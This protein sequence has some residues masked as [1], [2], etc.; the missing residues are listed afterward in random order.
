MDE[1]F[2]SISSED[3]TIGS[4]DIK[5]IEGFEFPKNDITGEVFPDCCNYHKTLFQNTGEWFKKFPNCCELHKKVALKY[6]FK[7]ENYSGLPVKVLN[8]VAFTEY[9]IVNQIKIDDWYKDITDY[10]ELNVWSFGQPAVGLHMYLDTITHYLKVTKEENLPQ[11]KKAKLIEFLESYYL[12]K[13]EGEETDWNILYS[14]YKKWLKIFPFE[15]SYFIDKRKHFEN[16]MPLADGKA[17][18]NSYTG[19]AKVK[20]HTYG[21]LRQALILLTES[22]L[23]NINGVT[24]FEKGMITDTEKIKLELVISSRK[25]QLKQRYENELK[26]EEQQVAKTIGEWLE[27]EKKFIDEIAPLLKSL[28]PAQ[29]EDKAG[30]SKPIIKPIFNVESIPAIFDLLKGF[31]NAED[32]TKFEEIL[33]TG[34]NVSSKL[35]FLDSG[36]R[37]ADAFKQLIKSDIITGCNQKEL[38]GWVFR[39]FNYKFRKGIKPFSERYL[40]DIISSNKDLCKNPI[41]NVKQD[42]TTGAFSI[43]KA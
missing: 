13:V 7:K 4:F 12:E 31:F 2:I 6:W 1:P 40:N 36:N 33:H 11:E 32:Q 29:P 21:S 8:Q 18:V 28:P 10:I 38:E 37:L 34:N 27:D 9:H 39:N 26:K 23:K 17:I 3:F 15:I 30:Q 24:L 19:L 42:K 41:L 5:P 22:L 43:V 35:I 14:I 20:M 16:L 25:L